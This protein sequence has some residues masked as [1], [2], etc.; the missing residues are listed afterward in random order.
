MLLF[1][2]IKTA[3]PENIFFTPPKQVSGIAGFMAFGIIQKKDTY[4]MCKCIVYLCPHHPLQ[5]ISNMARCD[6]PMSV[7]CQIAR[8]GVGS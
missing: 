8:N 3:V 4:N 5:M 2:F 6:Q 7:V 1:K